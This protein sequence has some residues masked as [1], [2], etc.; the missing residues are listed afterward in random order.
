MMGIVVVMIAVVSLTAF[1]QDKSSDSNVPEK[2][3]DTVQGGGWE[4]DFSDYSNYVCKGEPRNFGI[5]QSKSNDLKISLEDVYLSNGLLYFSISMGT[6]QSADN[7]VSS[8]SFYFNG[9]QR[10]GGGGAGTSDGGKFT[11]TVSFV[12]HS[13]QFIKGDQ[14]ET[15]SLLFGGV[16]FTA[17]DH[18]SCKELN[19]L[20]VNSYDIPVVFYNPDV[21]IS[22][23]NS[24]EAIAD[25][26]KIT[27]TGSPLTNRIELELDSLA[28]TNGVLSFDLIRKYDLIGYVGGYQAEWSNGKQLS[29]GGGSVSFDGNDNPEFPADLMTTDTDK[30]SYSEP[31]LPESFQLSRLGMWCND[32]SFTVDYKDPQGV[33]QTWTEKLP[34]RGT[35]APFSIIDFVQE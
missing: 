32:I 33:P 11:K 14:W 8:S 34:Y 1:A 27:S 25:H 35:G 19:P 28:N 30:F 31:Y 18:S 13:P 3:A 24:S 9:E 16:S 20:H 4:Y 10:G 22:D 6:S 23:P 21:V 15:F 5:I 29:G 2:S 7:A 12:Y 17:L 26:G